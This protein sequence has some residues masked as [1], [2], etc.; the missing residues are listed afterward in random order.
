[1]AIRTY[2]LASFYPYHY[3]DDFNLPLRFHPL[4][5]IP[6][7]DRDECQALHSPP[8]L[9]LP[10]IS[11]S[12]KNDDE[13]IEK[14]TSY[15]KAVTY[16]NFLA[17]LDENFQSIFRSLLEVDD[18]IKLIADNQINACKIPIE[19]MK[20]VLLINDQ[21]IAEN[22]FGFYRHLNELSMR[23]HI[24]QGTHYLSFK[25]SA[26]DGN[27]FLHRVRSVPK[28][29]EE[30][31][32]IPINLTAEDIENFKRIALSKANYDNPYAKDI[33]TIAMICHNRTTAPNNICEFMNNMIRYGHAQRDKPIEFLVLD[34]STDN[35]R[36][37]RY[38]EIKENAKA[39]KNFNINLKL[40]DEVQK[41]RLID[42][43]SEKINLANATEIQKKELIEAALGNDGG[44]GAQR[45]WADLFGA[46]TLDDDIHP[47][48][49]LTLD[50]QFRAV[51]VDF[52]GIISRALARPDIHS[53]NFE[54]SGKSGYEL[55]TTIK[56]FFNTNIGAD[57]NS[58]S[59]YGEV[60]CASGHTLTRV[61]QPSSSSTFIG[62][63]IQAKASYLLSDNIDLP[64][65]PTAENYLRIEDTVPMLLTEIFNDT[66][67]SARN[68]FYRV[69]G[70]VYHEINHIN[71]SESV[72]KQGILEPLACHLI[73]LIVQECF[74]DLDIKNKSS[75]I[76]IIGQRLM[77]HI[78]SKTII[79]IC[80]RY[81]DEVENSPR[82]I[83]EEWFQLVKIHENSSSN[84]KRGVVELIKKAFSDFG[85]I[86]FYENE[87]RIKDEPNWSQLDLSTIQDLLGI[88][89]ERYAKTMMIWPALVETA[90]KHR[91]ELLTM[92]N[93]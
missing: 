18:F 71:I 30:Y 91:E 25:I 6:Q 74:E 52:M 79:D 76:P 90:R 77:E 14:N 55:M 56:N 89:L 20:E 93:T 87:Y 13:S 21:D 48:C 72:I 62:G 88:E 12:N 19:I 83:L 9:S 70:S 27:F 47:Y 58:Y 80:K 3:D 73:G 81:E 61:N 34:D 39:Y 68:N 82:L 84:E 2:N 63:G 36:E 8:N 43:F 15:S 45:N 33:H 69:A 4:S 75:A 16:R 66:Q 28:Q 5:S 92:L 78:N 29:D 7:G 54:H 41:Q 51:P 57:Y 40:V 26:K 35:A 85:L 67:E 22:F 10:R 53:T 38:K 60:S 50:G 37:A 42:F 44:G 11:V 64:A 32:P 46:V 31:S 24:E 65:T 17:K 59:S 49:Y 86:D 1:M 23:L